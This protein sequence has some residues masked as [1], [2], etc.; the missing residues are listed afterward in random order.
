MKTQIGIVFGFLLITLF[1]CTSSQP[2]AVEETLKLA[3]KNRSELLTVL[4]HYQTADDSLKYKAA[5]YLIKNMPG[6]G[7]VDYT[8][9][10]TSGKKVD[11][12]VLDYPDYT[13][14][15]AAWDSI[16]A[17]RGPIDY[18]HSALVEDAQ[19]VRSQFLIETI[20][21]AFKAWREKP[22]TKH[23]TFDQFC[24]YVLPYRGSNEP[25]ESSRNY[26]LNK[27]AHLSER[28]KNPSDPVEAARL[29]NQD[30]KSWFVFNDRYY[31]HPT[32]QGVHEM[33]KSGMGR[34]EDM[35]NLAIYAMR[36]NALAVT[37]DYTPH[38]ADTGNN[39]AWNALLD[40]TGKAVPF[41]G[42]L[43]DPGA[44]SITNRVAKVYRKTYSQ[45]PQNLV[46]KVKK[47]TAVPGWLAGKYYRDVT[48]DYTSTSTITVPLDSL[49]PDSVHFAYVCV[50]NDGEWK[51]I[52][53]GKIKNKSVRF[54]DMGRN[55]AYLPAFY[56]HHSLK[57]AG[58]A[59]ILQTDGTLRLLSARESKQTLRLYSTTK[60]TRK[61]ATDSIRKAAFTPDSEYELFYWQSGWK[62]LG[63][64]RTA[65]NK[66]LI[67]TGAP[68]GALFWLVQKDSKKQERIFTF[69][70]NRQVW[71]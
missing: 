11:F 18:K 1:S 59:F 24:E 4:E 60:R 52:H 35:A 67:Y 51:A 14:M 38:W 3:G 25:L 48:K 63:I 34:C 9:Q 12:N 29:I 26:F 71:W 53:W 28:M 19:T 27:Y 57:P 2:K 68:K 37:S 16:E 46:F 42:A 44:Y 20:D 56:I 8:L 45:Q 49:P 36:A 17:L 47:G 43:F 30:V 41:M 65:H 21:L 31:R 6:H 66:P 7:F 54:R 70:N 40:S 61:D 23:L 55:I 10:D 58:K 62:S 64:K 15:V 39:H 32:D 22:W 13:T 33:L 50:F 5:L 69:E